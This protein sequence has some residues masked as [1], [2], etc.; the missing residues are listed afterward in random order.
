MLQQIIKG[1]KAIYNHNLIHRDI[2]PSN[3]F[4]GAGD[5]IKIGDFGFA[6]NAEECLHPCS[7]NIGSPLYMP[8]E[9]LVG[10]VYSF[11]SDIWAI[12]VTFLEMLAGKTPWKSKT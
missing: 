8:Y 4:V 6:I 1:Y 7:E 10:N 9:S 3:I 2:K 5:T 12:G 11:K